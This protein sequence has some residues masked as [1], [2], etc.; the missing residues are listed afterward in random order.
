[1]RWL[2]RLLH[3]ASTA[4]LPIGKPRRRAVRQIRVH[5]PDREGTVTTHDFAGVRNTRLVVPKGGS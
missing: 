1:M 4:P 5:W 2:T 3:V